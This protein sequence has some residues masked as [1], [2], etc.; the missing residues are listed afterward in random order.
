M[1]QCLRA[2]VEPY[3]RRNCGRT[4][5]RR[6]EYEAEQGNLIGMLQNLNTDSNHT[7]GH[8]TQMNLPEAVG[9]NP[10]TASKVGRGDT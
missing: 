9:S 7:K 3:G 8:E 5:K 10:T 2:M 1:R 6:T 4:A